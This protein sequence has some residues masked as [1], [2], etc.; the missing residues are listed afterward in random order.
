MINNRADGRKTDQFVKCTL[1][2]SVTTKTTTWILTCPL[3][4]WFPIAATTVAGDVQVWVLS[5]VSLL[6]IPSWHGLVQKLFIPSVRKSTTLV[7]MNLTREAFSFV[8]LDLCCIANFSLLLRMYLRNSFIE[9]ILGSSPNKTGNTKHSCLF[10]VNDVRVKCFLTFLLY[11][12]HV[13]CQ[14]NPMNG[15]CKLKKKDNYTGAGASYINSTC[16]LIS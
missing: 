3:N 7:T 11:T 9:S 1:C 14:T 5:S 12:T 6:G 2:T 16:S 4:C 10:R 8:F 13:Q 15:Q